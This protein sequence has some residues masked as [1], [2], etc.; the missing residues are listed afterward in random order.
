MYLE[1]QGITPGEYLC[2]LFFPPAETSGLHKFLHGDTGGMGSH[3]LFSNKKFKLVSH[4]ACSL[5][6]ILFQPLHS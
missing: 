6:H 2:A 4:A 1:S 5:R 3:N